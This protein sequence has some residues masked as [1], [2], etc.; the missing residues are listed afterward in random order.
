M[1]VLAGTH[2]PLSSSTTLFSGS[3]PEADESMSVSARTAAQA[4]SLSR[5]TA[6]QAI[7]PTAAVGTSASETGSAVVLEAA[8]ECVS[9]TSTLSESAYSSFVSPQD[10]FPPPSAMST[11]T[12]ASRGS[13]SPDQ[14]TETRP[15]P[16][17]LTQ[18]P[19]CVSGGE[20][21]S[22]FRCST[23][24]AISVPLDLAVLEHDTDPSPFSKFEHLL[25]SKESPLPK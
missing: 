7:N 15:P 6:A 8:L 23:D 14:P 12:K 13:T 17:E 11:L 3:I 2:P 22:F 21:P 16:P 19:M 20:A 9:G 5:G 18:S 24:L 4:E 10:R 25:G 1:G